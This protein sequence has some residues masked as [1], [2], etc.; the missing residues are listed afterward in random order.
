MS[1][2][3]LG[4]ENP[5]FVVH[6][7]GPILYINE[8]GLALFE[9]DSPD[10]F[11]GESIFE[12]IVERHQNDVAEH[13]QRIHSGE[14]A[15]AGRTFDLTT[16]SLESKTVIALS[17]LVEWDGAERIQTL[18]FDIDSQLPPS[19]SE[20]T[21]DA[22]PIGISVADATRD[23]EPLIYVNDG[24]VELT[25]YSR[26]EIL[27]R[28]CR[29]LQGEET[30]EDTVAEIRKAIDAEEPIVTELL[31]YRKDGSMF[32]NRLSIQP[33]RD[34]TGT[35]THFLGFQQDISDEKLYEQ[36]RTLF[37]L[38][39][40]AIEQVVFITDADGSIEY[41]NPAFERT[42]GYTA[43][44][45][46]G[47]NPRLLK[48]EQ[49]DEEFYRELWETISA[50][51]V[52]EAELVNR[53]KSGE[54]YRIKQKIVPITNERDEITHFVAIEEDITDI[55]FIEEVLSVMDRVLRHNVRNSVTAIDGYA[56]LL[57]GELDETEHRAAV[58]TIRD[59][60]HKLEQVSSETRTIRELFRRR[61]S[62]HSLSVGA[63]EGFI[64]TRREQHPAAE[65]ELGMDIDSGVEIQNGSLLQLAI[66]E[67]LENAVVHNDQDHPH[68]MVKVDQIESESEVR[69]EIAEN[70][71]GIPAD[72]WEVIT[73]GKETAL[74]HST[75]IGLWLIHWTVTALGGT[76]ERRDNKPRGTILRYLIPIGA[77][78]HSDQFDVMDR[79]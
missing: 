24:F 53:R 19:L 76:L 51:D 40:D 78:D 39:A 4:D 14:L 3:N 64:E 56:N 70:G 21:M 66:D 62:Q 8:S 26:S 36:E 45:A 13:F 58:Q 73:A 79:L 33:V 10:A 16:P 71:P 54:R 15:T 18:F 31:N 41:V 50:G 37:E 65:I 55:Q 38:Q 27:G 6:D 32:W 25:G 34:D 20:Q 77:G 5:P 68:V 42:T 63:I 23:D 49:Q 29:F 75:G 67:A 35:V 12:F 60:T 22:S 44:E 74:A 9:A 2:R 57:E 43:E 28:N 30:S 7:N 72:Q 61:H 1:V 11:A 47:E 48:S 69:I 17:T 59:H 52:W 46:I